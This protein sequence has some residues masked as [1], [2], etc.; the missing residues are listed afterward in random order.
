[1][2]MSLQSAQMV[3]SGPCPVCCAEVVPAGSVEESEVLPCPECQSMLV[4]DGFEGQRLILNEGPAIE[5]D[6][7]E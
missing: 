5:E 3:M 1:M 2:T 6:W 4:V 7:G